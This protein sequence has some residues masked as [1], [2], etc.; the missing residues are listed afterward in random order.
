MFIIS[1][2]SS[3]TGLHVGLWFVFV[4]RLFGLP[5]VGVDVLMGVPD[6]DGSSSDSTP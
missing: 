2:F 1:S 6:S 3:F 5:L 4:F